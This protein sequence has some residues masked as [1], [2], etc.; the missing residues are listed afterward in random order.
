LLIGRLLSWLLI[1]RLGLLVGG[2][3]L[4]VALVWL[5]SGWLLIGRLGWP[6]LGLRL[7]GLLIANW[8]FHHRLLVSL[9]GVAVPLLILL[10]ITEGVRACG[11]F[12]HDFISNSIIL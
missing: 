4:L 12:A 5:R 9:A 8:L 11:T 3:G 2:L 10:Y 6:V 7:G 1:G